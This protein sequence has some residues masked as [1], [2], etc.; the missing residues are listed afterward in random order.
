MAGITHSAFRRLVA[1]FGGYGA[2]YT[3]MLPTQ[4][5]LSEN[6]IS[7]PTT[8]II[9]QPTTHKVA[10]SSKNKALTNTKLII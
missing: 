9:K 8:R 10:S 3:E 6:L 2:L 1:G 4:T 5:L 7:S